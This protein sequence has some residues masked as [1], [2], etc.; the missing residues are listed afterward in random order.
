MHKRNRPKQTIRVTKELSTNSYVQFMHL[1][2][3]LASFRLA[4]IAALVLA[5]LTR[6]RP[7]IEAISRMHVRSADAAYKSVS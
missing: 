3:L 1:F 5:I 2:A 4:A 7:K 6:E